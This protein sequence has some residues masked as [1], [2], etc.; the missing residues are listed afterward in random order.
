MSEHT[1]DQDAHS[2]RDNLSDQATWMRLVYMLLFVVAF[3]LA[4]I[5]I[6]AIAIFQFLKVLFT[7]E[8]NEKLKSLGGDLAVY[9]GDM[10]KFL[11]FQTDKMPYPVSDWGE[12]PKKKKSKAQ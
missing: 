2:T 9:I 10:T 7:K 6:A 12:P 1:L 11:T 4:E 8:P 3:N 5:L